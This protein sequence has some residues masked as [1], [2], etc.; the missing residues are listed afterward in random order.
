MEGQAAVC[1]H[2]INCLLIRVTL[3]SPSATL[4]SPSTSI[5]KDDSKDKISDCPMD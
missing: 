3:L 5:Q 2:I 4:T 1:I